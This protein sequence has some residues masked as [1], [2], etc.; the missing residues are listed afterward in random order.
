[1]IFSN[2]S[3]HSMKRIS[4]AIIAMVLG[5]ASTV[6]AQ[7]NSQF[8]AQKINE[9]SNSC[10]VT[11][12]D[13][14]ITAQYFDKALGLTHIYFNQRHDGIDLWDANS[15]LHI[16]QYD[17]VT[18]LN[19][20]FECNVASLIENKQANI[21]SVAAL[22]KAASYKE[23]EL[24]N[25]QSK[26]AEVLADGTIQYDAAR[27]LSTKPYYVKHNGKMRLAWNCEVYNEKTNDWWHI[28]VDAQTGE[29]LNENNWTTHCSQHETHQRI[30]HAESVKPMVHAAF[31]Q[32]AGKKTEGAQYS[33]FPMPIESPGH[34]AQRTVSVMPDLVAS[35]F[36]WHDTNGVAGAD[37]TITRG[38]NVFAKEDTL[39]RNGSGYSPNGGPNLV[40]DFPYTANVPARRNLDAAIVNLFYWNNLIHDIFYRYGFDEPAG[41]FQVNNYGK[42]GLGRD[43][44]H[45]DAQD[46][47]GTNNAN[48]QTPPDGSIGRM[49]MFLWN[50]PG[51]NTNRNVIIDGVSI[52]AVYANFGTRAN[53]TITAQVVV[54][55]DSTSNPTLACNTIRNDVAGKIVLIDRGTCNYVVKAQN[56]QAAGALAVLVINTSEQTF[57]MTGSG[58]NINIPCLMIPLSVGNTYKNRILNNGD[59]IVASVFNSASTLVQFDS[60]FDNGVITHEYGHGISTRLAGGPSNSN[61]LS[62][63]EQA[64]EGWSDFFALCLTAKPSDTILPGSARG[65]ATWLVAQQNNGL[66]IRPF[67]YSRSMSVNPLTYNSVRSVSIPH[68]VGTVWCSMLYDIYWDMVDKYGFNEDIYDPTT[69]GNNMTLQLVMDGL[70]LQPCNPGFVDLRNAVIAADSLRY[71]GANRDLLWRAFARR[72]LG[73]SARQGLHTSVTDGTE[74]FDLPADVLPTSINEKAWRSLHLWPNP[75]QNELNIAVP[76]GVA[77]MTV[78]IY[79]ISGKR[80]LSQQ[81]A[82]TWQGNIKLDIQSIETGVYMV[83]IQSAGIKQSTKLVI[84]K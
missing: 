43:G 79:D 15:S 5:G 17:Q 22:M 62:G 60:D 65:I 73:F 6:N 42:G 36:G 72:G 27:H 44:V 25:V 57:A 33:V 40:F 74:A 39:A 56:A 84:T 34:G 32:K 16:N 29:V 49:Q 53:D 78:S 38:N 71:G 47:S 77:E 10:S 50:P 61:C 18:R 76:S 13:I 54:A 26:Q 20:L 8:V 1:M 3:K 59:S 69:G 82:T 31:Y 58:S 19:N 51:A 48:F 70:K 81:A 52:T 83:E 35:P 75:A 68:G 7:Y 24:P 45:A 23:V 46:G 80:V 66:G 21:N 9:Y 41:N 30:Q 11:P 64:G 12:S 55:N 14:H 4:I 63:N 28:R 2:T 67:R 37:Y